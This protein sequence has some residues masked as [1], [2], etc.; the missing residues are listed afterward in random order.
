MK[1][2][3]RNISV[4]IWSRGEDKIRVRIGSP[5]ED[6]GTGVL[7]VGSDIWY[8]LPKSGSHDQD[9]SIDDDDLVDGKSLH[10][11]DLVKAS[12]RSRL[13]YRPL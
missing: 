2:W 12:H 5:R 3:Q 8:Y 9:A 11:D 13:L 1:N 6:A 10:A 4:Q 7:K